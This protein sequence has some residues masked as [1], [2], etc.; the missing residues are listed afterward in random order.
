M[1]SIHL[2]MLGK[3]L[4]CWCALVSAAVQSEI[5]DCP[6]REAPYS[7]DSP[8]LDVLLSE[9]AVEAVKSE[10]P[11]FPDDL[12]PFLVG[13][14]IPSFAAIISLRSNA[15]ALGF[16]ASSLARMDKLLRTVPVTRDDQRARCARY[17]NDVPELGVLTASP[18]VLVFEKITGFDHGDSVVAAR[19]AIERIA[20]QQG[21]S[22]Y[23]TDRGGVFTAQALANFDAVVW[24]NVSGD[25]LTVRQ[26]AAF[27]DYIES[28]G[29]F[30]GLHATGGD[31]I[32]PW[33]WFASTLLGARFI[34]HPGNPQ[35]Q[36]ATL[37]TEANAAGIGQGLAPGWAME[38]EWYSFAETPRKDS[39][40]VLLR[41]DESTYSPVSW[42]GT[43][44]SMGSDHPLAWMRRVGRGKAI[45]SAVGHRRESYEHAAYE[46]FLSQAL[47]WAMAPNDTKH[48]NGR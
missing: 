13:T 4:V 46:E 28:G 27:R 26:R 3:L 19:T 34:G 5:I 48:G 12:P 2:Q 24:N 44:I 45:Y 37:L 8:L 17:D 38:E 10:L 42:D 35:F 14:A 1:K 36:K 39:V 25:A 16:D 21:W 32:Y 40:S 7:V 47:S 11:G 22:V 6:L 43:D 31:S 41:V 15:R 9:A 29:S 18:A 20:A 23:T 30:V 33:Q